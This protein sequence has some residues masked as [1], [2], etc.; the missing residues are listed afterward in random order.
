MEKERIIDAHAHIFPEK[1]AAKA[2]ASIGDFYDLTMH[3]GNGTAEAL[4][5]S[6][7]QIGTERYLVC[8]TATKPGQVQAI[9][10]FIWAESQA[11]PE[12]VPFATLHPEMEGLEEEMER[13]LSRG[14]YGL[15]LHPDFQE[16]HIHDMNRP[17]DE[18]E[19]V[20]LSDLEKEYTRLN[21]MVDTGDA[22][23]RREMDIS[24]QAGELVGKLYDAFLKQ[25]KD[26][27]AE[28]TLP[29]SR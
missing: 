28:S 22:H 2:V 23:I 6:G 1:I 4:L 12:F 10:D 16:F 11:H 19:V 7:K 20:M 21:F 25:Y 15:K 8:S 5:E 3:D 24:M 29:S 17:N 18:A 9:N 26:P 14:Y 13:I 27:S